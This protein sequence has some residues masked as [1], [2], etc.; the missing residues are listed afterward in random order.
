VIL[1]SGRLDTNTRERAADLG[2]TRAIEKPFAANHLIDL[3]R[4][5]LLE[6]D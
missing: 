3:I 2:I 6:R 4:N 1:I 5:A